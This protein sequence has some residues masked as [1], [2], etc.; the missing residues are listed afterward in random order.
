MW[1]KDCHPIMTS[2]NSYKRHLEPL[3]HIQIFS[4][5]SVA[6]LF[7]GIN[8]CLNGPSGSGRDTCQWLISGK[9]L[10]SLVTPGEEYP[11]LSCAGFFVL[12][13]VHTVFFSWCQQYWIRTQAVTRSPQRACGSGRGEVNPTFLAL[14]EPL[15]YL[16]STQLRFQQSYLQPFT[17]YT[18][19]V[20]CLLPCRSSFPV[21]HSTWCKEHFLHK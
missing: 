2:L 10:S 9:S 17:E 3:N 11:K 8:N 1:C 6:E 5:D 13:W 12:G 18:C 21:F 19:L 15:R 7:S 14:G 16:L 4:N 20:L